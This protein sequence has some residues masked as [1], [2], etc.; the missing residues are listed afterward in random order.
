MPSHRN[1]GRKFFTVL[2]VGPDVVTYIVTP[3]YVAIHERDNAMSFALRCS[4]PNRISCIL[5]HRSS[6]RHVEMP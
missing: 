4:E 2:N 5:Q 6:H 1:G 3:A